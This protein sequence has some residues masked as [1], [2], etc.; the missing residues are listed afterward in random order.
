MDKDFQN[1]LLFFHILLILLSL[2]WW[3]SKKNNK[4]NLIDFK[5]KYV[6]MDR[7]ENYVILVPLSWG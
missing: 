4:H 1:T 7:Y 5:Q 6:E 2:N 3:F